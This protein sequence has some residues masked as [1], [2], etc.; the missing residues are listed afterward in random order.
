MDIAHRT[1]HEERP[2][3]FVRLMDIIIVIVVWFSFHCEL[4]SYHRKVTLVRMCMES[5]QIG[6]LSSDV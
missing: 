1:S 3:K 6:D 4:E 5:D 2:R